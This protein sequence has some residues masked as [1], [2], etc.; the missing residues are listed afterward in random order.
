M[1]KILDKDTFKKYYYEKGKTLTEIAI[2]FSVSQTTVRNRM[3]GWGLQAQTNSQ[4][5]S[6]IISEIKHYN[7]LGYSDTEIATVLKLDIKYINSWRI[8]LSLPKNLRGKKTLVDEL[9]PEKLQRRLDNLE[10]QESIAKIYN[11]SDVT[12]SNYMKEWGIKPPTN[13]ER[14]D[15]NNPNFLRISKNFEEY[16]EEVIA[17]T[18]TKFCDKYSIAITQYSDLKNMLNISKTKT[19]HSQWRGINT[20]KLTK[21]QKDLIIASMLG[22]GGFRKLKYGIMYKEFHSFKQLSYLQKKVDILKPF[23]YEVIP[24]GNGFLLKTVPI[25]ELEYLYDLFYPK[26]ETWKQVP[27]EIIN[28]F[29]I[30]WLGYWFLDD[31][32]Y[33]DGGNPLVSN[34]FIKKHQ[35]VTLK[36]ILKNNNIDIIVKKNL[37]GFSIRTKS[38][39]P[40]YNII[41]KYA[42]SDMLYKIPEKFRKNKDNS[43][44]SNYLKKQWE[45]LYSHGFPYPH[46]T[47]ALWEIRFKFLIDFKGSKT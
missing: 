39:K 15:L 32:S 34:H 30:N 22:D 2:L 14:R 18:R 28:N 35:Y 10:T 27:D 40:F 37:T 41:N 13:T 3:K 24:E 44:S 29:D 19:G 17:L 47:E 45:I 31:G 25:K 12:I 26:G 23:I 5:N 1:E 6:K 46:V 16:R 4:K 38:F 8:K 33:F 36:K 7:S 20:K 9:T 11:T 42:T 43:Q 21:E